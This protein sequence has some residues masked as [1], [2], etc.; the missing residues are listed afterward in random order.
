[1]ISYALDLNLIPGGVLP[2]IDLSQYDHGQSVECDLYKGPVPYTI[3]SG[4]VIYVEGTKPDK[5]GFQYEATIA[6]NKVTFEV[7]NQ[8]T[9]CG[10]EVVT[11][12]VLTHSGDR[13]AT[14]NFIL[15]VEPAALA[16][17]T[18]I[19]ETDLPIVQQIP[20]YIEQI[21][22]EDLD[23]IRQGERV[24]VNVSGD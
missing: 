18:I 5:T 3:P 16:N 23:Y 8:M 6:S 12:L 2:R 7:T 13:I 17:D 21:A 20:E 4:S 14:I 1:M 15:N 22:R 10:G 11:E 9:A 24:F 19:S